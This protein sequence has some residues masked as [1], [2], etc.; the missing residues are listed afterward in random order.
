M[1][2]SFYVSTKQGEKQK[3]KTRTCCKS[4]SNGPKRDTRDAEGC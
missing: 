3:K 2:F 1:K 4:S